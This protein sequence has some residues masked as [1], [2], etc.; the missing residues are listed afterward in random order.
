M[1]VGDFERTVEIVPI[2]LPEE[3]PQD[4]PYEP[5]PVVV[6]PEKEPAHV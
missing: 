6:E 4:A 2:E 1:Q 5:E 3:T